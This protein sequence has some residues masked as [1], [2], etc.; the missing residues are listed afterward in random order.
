MKNKSIYVKI[1]STFR[2]TYVHMYVWYTHNQVINMQNNYP[3][4]VEKKCGKRRLR[5]YKIRM[6]IKVKY[7]ESHALRCTYICT[8]ILTLIYANF[9]IM[10]YN[11]FSIYIYVYII[12]I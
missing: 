8:Y 11:M 4:L 6:F 10:V 7:A 12:C 5:F 9:F 2:C 3:T 1:L